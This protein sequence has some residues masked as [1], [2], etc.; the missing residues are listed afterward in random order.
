MT[1]ALST[2]WSVHPHDV[3][4]TF[5]HGTLMETIYFT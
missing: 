5:L 3:K 4:N 2:D 1:L